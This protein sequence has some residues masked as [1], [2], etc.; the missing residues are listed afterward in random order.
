ML[1]IILKLGRTGFVV[2]ITLISVTVATSIS[3]AILSLLG[4]GISA[5]VLLTSVILPA[6]MTPLL[7][8]YIVGLL[9][10]TYRS[11]QQF[12]FDLKQ[13]NS[14]TTN[15]V[16]FLKSCESVYQLIR[17]NNS[18]L[19][20]LRIDID[21]LEIP[22]ETQKDNSF[23]ESILKSFS[24]LL[25]Q[26]LRKSDLAG[27]L[28][29]QHFILGLPD[30]N[31]AGAIHLAEKIRSM[32]NQ[33]QLTNSGNLVKYS[34]WIGVSV[35]DKYNPVSFESLIRQSDSALT[36]AKLSGRGSIHASKLLPQSK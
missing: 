13:D 15:E 25:R 8:W 3:I 35:F 17:R 23:S 26:C 2:L 10:K 7:T 9:I 14:T 4:S 29:N 1:K 12:L 6:I 16:A 20:I 27:R 34:V 33:S 30:T 11:E 19:A 31:M 5:P 32:V 22:D 18:S 36:E 28:L 24:L 21:Y